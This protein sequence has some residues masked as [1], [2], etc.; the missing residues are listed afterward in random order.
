MTKKKTTLSSKEILQETIEYYG[1]DPD[2]RRAVK[3]NSC[4]YNYK[5]EYTI[6]HCAVGR[7]LLPKYQLMSNATWN[8]DVS[9][10][11]LAEAQNHYNG[12]EDKY[13]LPEKYLSLDD[14]LQEK[15]RGRTTRFW[16]ELQNLHDRK[17]YWD[18]NGLTPEGIKYI[19]ECDFLAL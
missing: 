15:Y 16:V 11:D 7:C 2:E 12:L 18:Q 8:E 19:D 6:K 10:A 17:K 1:K 3:H 9:A 4:V 13:D 14:M 5:T